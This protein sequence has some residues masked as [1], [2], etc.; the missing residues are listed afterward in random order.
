MTDVTS[1]EQT[2]VEELDLVVGELEQVIEEGAAQRGTC[3]RHYY[4]I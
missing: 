3:I 2:E 4:C 1:S